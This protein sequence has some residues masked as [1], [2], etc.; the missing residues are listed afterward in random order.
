MVLHDLGLIHE[1][2][3]VN[4]VLVFIPPLLWI[5]VAAA[6]RIRRPF[7]TLLSVGAVYGA[8][9]ALIH[10][11]FW[12]Q[13]FPGG[14]PSLGGNLADLDPVLQ[15]VIMRSFAVVPGIVTGLLVGAVCG[16]L[17]AGLCALLPRL[18]TGPS[19]G[20]WQS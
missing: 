18:R 14:T 15:E 10:Q 20:P 8:L 6:L 12:H 4:A 1:G 11:L 3:F 5:G 2:T 9:L 19:T 16:L 13:A 17:A 7:L